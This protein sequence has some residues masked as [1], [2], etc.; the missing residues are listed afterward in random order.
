MFFFLKK[1]IQIRFFQNNNYYF[2]SLKV[3]KY[4]L[5]I[6]LRK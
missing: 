4:Q 2:H 3:Q 1:N 6:A 5:K